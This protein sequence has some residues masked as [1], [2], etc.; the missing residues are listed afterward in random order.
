[1]MARC[2]VAA[3]LLLVAVE[4][5]P[6]QSREFS[7]VSVKPCEGNAGPAAGGRKGDGRPSS[8]VR[9]HLPC[10]TVANLIQ[11][12]YVN[13]AQDRFDPLANMPVTGGP[14]WINSLEYE[15]DAGAE[16]PRDSGVINGAM[17]RKLLESRFAL[18][19]HQEKRQIPVYELVVGNRNKLKLKRSQPGSC[20]V[21]DPE[22]PPTPDLSKPL[23]LLCGM[24]R[25]NDTGTDVNG[26]TMADLARMLSDHSDRKIVDRT[27]LT[28][29]FDI[30]LDLYPTEFNSTVSAGEAA[31]RIAEEIRKIGLQLRSARG[32]GELL[33]IDSLSKPQEN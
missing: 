2:T 4:A 17:L 15:I 10:Q 16:T 22:H 32:T 29:T 9:L 23:L 13:Y 18:R 3:V 14:A 21:F 5:A 26:A 1:M 25:G 19:T 27:G 7:V 30:H 6:A 33:V 12:A 20:V 28:G 24:M 8:P 31:S 11:W